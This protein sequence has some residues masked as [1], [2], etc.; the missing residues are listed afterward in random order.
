MWRAGGETRRLIWHNGD[1]MLRWMSPQM[2]STQFVP[3]IWWYETPSE[4]DEQTTCTSFIIRLHWLGLRLLLIPS[5]KVYQSIRSPSVIYAAPLSKQM[6]GTNGMYTDLKQ[7]LTFTTDGD[8]KPVCRLIWLVESLMW[9][10][11]PDSGW[12]VAGKC[13]SLGTY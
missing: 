8:L 11:A 7:L 12:T 4:Q 10:L 6:S 5:L 2:E 3:M 9:S 13:F 1:S